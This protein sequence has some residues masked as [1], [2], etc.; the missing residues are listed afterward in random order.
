MS[1]KCG[2]VCCRA[3][4]SASCRAV[5]DRGIEAVSVE[6][7]PCP[8]ERAAHICPLGW[9]AGR[10][11]VSRTVIILAVNAVGTGFS[12]NTVSVFHF[13]SVRM[14]G[15]MGMEFVGCVA[16]FR[17]TVV[18]KKKHA[19]ATEAAAIHRTAICLV[20]RMRFGSIGGT[21]CR[22]EE[23]GISSSG[24]D[25]IHLSCSSSV[26]EGSPSSNWSNMVLKSAKSLSASGER[27]YSVSRASSSNEVLH[28]EV[29]PSSDVFFICRHVQSLLTFSC[30]IICFLARDNMV[31]TTPSVAPMI[32]AISPISRCST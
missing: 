29:K 31:R 26:K 21:V 5:S 30:S 15:G 6:D 25:C 14:V 20:R 12:M 8:V 32:R 7:V 13:T 24:H 4:V 19:A 3:A 23:P 9:L 17:E 10:T 22:A 28:I 18:P 1:A 11:I 27:K 2:M 16:S